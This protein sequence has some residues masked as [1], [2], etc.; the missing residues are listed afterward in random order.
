MPE[1]SK[2]PDSGG[3]A[4]LGEDKES[5]KRI[6]DQKVGSKPL[7]SDGFFRIRI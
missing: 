2:K 6:L 7:G 5:L 4:M 1:M 3:S